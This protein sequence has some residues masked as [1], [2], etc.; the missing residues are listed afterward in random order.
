[1]LTRKFEDRSYR[2]CRPFET[3]NYIGHMCYRHCTKRKYFG[4]KKCKEW[5]TDIKDMTSK[6]GHELFMN[7]GFILINEKRVR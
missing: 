4:S 7:G 6:E 3:E 1:M 5:K 2:P